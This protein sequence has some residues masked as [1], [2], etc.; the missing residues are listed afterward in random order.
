MGAREGRGGVRKHKHGELGGQRASGDPSASPRRQ[1]DM[2]LVGILEAVEF[3]LLSVR[4]T[5]QAEG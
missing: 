5:L 4:K 3:Q 2:Q 1:W